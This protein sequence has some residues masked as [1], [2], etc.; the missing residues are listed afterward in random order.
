MHLFVCVYICIL[1]LLSRFYVF[2]SHF[3]VQSTEYRI[4]TEAHTQYKRMLREKLKVVS[5][6]LE[7][8]KNIIML[9]IFLFHLLSLPSQLVYP[10][11]GI[12]CLF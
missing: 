6:I 9:Y 4:A 7:H 2:Y 10:K 3:L 12:A 11:I 5:L 1:L 8:M